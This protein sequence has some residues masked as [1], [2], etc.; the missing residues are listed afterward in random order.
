MRIPLNLPQNEDMEKVQSIMT[1]PEDTPGGFD[2][3][4][5]LEEEL[6]QPCPGGCGESSYFC[7]CE[8]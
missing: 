7:K 1:P 2:F 4:A 6:C 3:A 5:Q 8:M